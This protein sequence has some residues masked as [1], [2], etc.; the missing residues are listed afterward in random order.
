M[1]PVGLG[2]AS[3]SLGLADSAS[4]PEFQLVNCSSHCE[5]HVQ[6]HVQGAWAPLCAAHWD[7]ADATV[8]CQQLNAGNAIYTTGRPLWGRG[9]SHVASCVSLVGTEPHL[10][11]CPG[12]ALG[13]LACTLGNSASALCSSECT[14]KEERESVGGGQRCAKDGG[15]G[16]PVRWKGG[17]G[18]QRQRMKGVAVLSAGRGDRGVQR[19]ER[20]CLLWRAQDPQPEPLGP[21]AV[22]RRP[23]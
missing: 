5:G 3:G 17:R 14:V 15:N 13:A 8:P 12:R 18:V 10:L 7:L 11:S 2:T 21:L 22:P 16:S 1:G 23:P 4:P 20:S 9:C 6:L 19:L